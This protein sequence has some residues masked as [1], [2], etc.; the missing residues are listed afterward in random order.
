MLADFD[1]QNF[2]ENHRMDYEEWQSMFK[3]GEVVVYSARTEQLELAALMVLKTTLID[4]GMWYFYSIAV[5]EQYRGMS[6]GT[7]L[8]NKAIES[9]IAT[10][11]ITSHCHIENVAS[12]AFHKSLGFRAI[13][14]VPDF[15]GDYEDAIMWSRPR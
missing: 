11:I 2:E 3:T 12:I 9:E 6:F 8:F 10:G 4:C 13:E 15:Y 5:A 1:L 7:R 14:Y